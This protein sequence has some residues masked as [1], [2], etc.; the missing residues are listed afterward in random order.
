MALGM[1]CSKKSCN[2]LKEE[3]IPA[4]SF[5]LGWLKPLKMCLSDSYG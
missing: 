2:E 4:D 1:T 5:V 3:C